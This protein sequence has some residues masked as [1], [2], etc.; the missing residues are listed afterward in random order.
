MRRRCALVLAGVFIAAVSLIAG[1]G[2]AGAAGPA[3]TV[4]PSAGLH[5]GQ[6]VTVHGTGF[7]PTTNGG[8][9]TVGTCRAEVVADPPSAPTLCSAD[10]QF[11]VPVDSNGTFTT[12]L[13]AR[14]VQPLFMG[15]GTV[16]CVSTP[17]A[18]VVI[19]IEV[20]F[21]G[22]TPQLVFAS[23]PISFGP[24]S[25]Q[26]CLLHPQNFTNRHGHAFHGFFDCA[27]SLF[28]SRLHDS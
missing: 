21:S 9:L 10:A 2:P 16:D 14:R 6:A 26:D 15:T 28:L 17:H 19:G 20:A 24:E 22:G 1:V 8:S 5:D 12:Y 18:C 7:A 3:I 4:V 13:T 25:I 11:P 23:A 27:V